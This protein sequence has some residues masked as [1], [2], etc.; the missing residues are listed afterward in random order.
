MIMRLEPKN[1]IGNNEFRLETK[2]VDGK[3]LIEGKI[4]YVLNPKL[5]N[6]LLS[7]KQYS[8]VQTFFPIFDYDNTSSIYV[9]CIIGSLQTI[10]CLLS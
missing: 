5:T 8:V 3:Q 7:L 2:F 4:M 9:Q 10:H 1:Y 6:F